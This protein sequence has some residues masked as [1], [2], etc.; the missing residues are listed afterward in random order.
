[1][2]VP[3]AS[4]NSSFFEMVVDTNGGGPQ[5]VPA[6]PTDH[7]A[8]WETHHEEGQLA[9]DVAESPTHVIVISTL[10]G[11]LTNTLE[12]FVHNDLLTI[13]GVR[14]EPVEAHTLHYFH[15][16]CFWG[17]FSRTIVLPVD[18]KGELAEAEYKNGILMVRVPKEKRERKIPILIVEE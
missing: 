18:V 7:I 10:A 4:H 9:V 11:A 13:R 17:K 8:E 16:E 12:V 15:K 6:S 2:S 14:V 1:M 5:V 3:H